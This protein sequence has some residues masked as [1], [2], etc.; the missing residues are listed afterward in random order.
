MLRTNNLLNICREE[1]NQNTDE[2]TSAFM[3]ECVCVFLKST[4]V[5]LA[6]LLGMHCC[7]SLFLSLPHT[8]AAPKTHSV[9]NLLTC[10]LIQSIIYQAKPPQLTE[11]GAKLCSA[12]L[13]LSARRARGNQGEA[14]LS[15]RETSPTRGKR[16]AS[17]SLAGQSQARQ[18]HILTRAEHRQAL[19]L[20]PHAG[21]RARTAP[22]AQDGARAHTRTTSTRAARARA[23]STG[24]TV[25]AGHVEGEG[26]AVMAVSWP[27]P[28]SAVRFLRSDL[29][30]TPSRARQGPCQQRAIG[31]KIALAY[32]ANGMG[33]WMT[34]D[35]TCLK[36][37][38][39]PVASTPSTGAG[40][41]PCPEADL[42]S[43]RH[44]CAAPNIRAGRTRRSTPRKQRPLQTSGWPPHKPHA[45][46]TT[47]NT[48]HTRHR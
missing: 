38:T 41:R 13:L 31:H 29:Q 36:S 20:A 35:R 6:W 14:N 25:E 23:T 30:A 16:R 47:C 26:G 42:R 39:A 46:D 11:T 28:H 19:S 10:S 8:R 48:R 3:F 18:R 45:C 43:Q 34:G 1:T 33:F 5:K 7:L 21:A 32:G 22:P 2:Q 27:R 37:E 12:L 4:H 44:T 17:R 15:G 24:R 40:R 9:L